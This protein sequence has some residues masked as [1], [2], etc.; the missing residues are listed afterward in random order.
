MPR[1]RLGHRS[2]LVWSTHEPGTGVVL[3]GIGAD[4]VEVELLSTSS[5]TG[6]TGADP[7]GGA[8]RGKGE[9]LASESLTGESLARESP[10]DDSPKGEN[11]EAHSE[12]TDGLEGT[13]DSEGTSDSEGTDESEGTGK[14]PECNSGSEQ[15]SEVHQATRFK[16]EQ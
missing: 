8:L 16:G 11:E 15:G 4:V 14:P 12:R 3:G 1:Q 5:S 10:K 2:A 6:N 7:G 13:G 9:S